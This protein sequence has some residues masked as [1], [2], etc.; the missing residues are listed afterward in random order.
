VI[1]RAGK[2]LRLI[3]VMRI[4][5]VFKVNLF[6]FLVIGRAGKVLRLMRVMRINRDFKYIKPINF[7]GNLRSME[8]F[9]TRYS[10]PDFQG[11]QD[12]Q[13]LLSVNM[14]SNEGRPS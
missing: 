10:L 3:R 11:F 6:P 12:N 1:G 7:S 9:S 2:V 14:T 8:V 13:N 5:R 4:L